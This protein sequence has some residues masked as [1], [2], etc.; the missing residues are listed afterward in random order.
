MSDLTIEQKATNSDTHEHIDTVVKF[1]STFKRELTDRMIV[2]DYSKLKSPE[3]EIFTEYTPKLKGTTYG[4]DEYKKYLK[5]MQVALDHHYEKNSHHP[6]H[7]E[8]GINDMTL[9]DIVEMFCD[10]FAATER[11][12]DGDIRESIKINTKRFGI[13]EQ[14]AKIF[15]NT[16]SVLK[17][18]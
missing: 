6:E 10:W 8:N 7:W 14:L 13:S 3:V 1:I 9:I 17:R 18:N 15:D 16:V 2:H 11:H 4:S 12:A 5:E